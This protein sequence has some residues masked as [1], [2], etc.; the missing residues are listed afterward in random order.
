MSDQPF[1]LAWQQS[2]K[3][4]RSDRGWSAQERDRTTPDNNSEGWIHLT[5]LCCKLDLPI[6]N[7]TTASINTRSGR[8]NLKSIIVCQVPGDLRGRNP[9]LKACRVQTDYE[10][11]LKLDFG[12]ALN[13][14]AILSNPALRLHPDLARLIGVTWEEEH[15]DLA[16]GLSPALVLDFA[17]VGTLVD[18]VQ[19]KPSLP[20]TVKTEVFCGI[21]E[22]LLAY[23]AAVLSMGTS[24]WRMCSSKQNK[25]VGTFPT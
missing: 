17:D 19:R 23:I 3:S 10:G 21:G 20:F 25:M 18:L 14:V 16:L 7:P 8:G 22:G 2:R 13:E 9:I 15:P 12:T 24:R 1:F 11:K 4:R 5:T 6:F